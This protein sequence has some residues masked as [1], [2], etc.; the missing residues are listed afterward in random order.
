MKKQHLLMMAA[1]ASMSL[2][3]TDTAL[4]GAG[5]A[6]EF[7][8]V[9]TMVQDWVEGELGKFLALGAFSVGAGIGLARQ[10]LMYIVQGIGAAIA[11]YYT[12]GVID[13]IIA[14]TLVDFGTGGTAIGWT[15][16]AAVAV[17]G[18]AWGLRRLLDWTQTW[19]R[20]FRLARA[21]LPVVG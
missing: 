2:L 1:I 21:S 16:L 11:V 5:G 13:N 18:L 3:L 8:S 10:N 20:A 7:G 9:R 17:G 15:A 14:A 19:V 4:A 12:P 6:A